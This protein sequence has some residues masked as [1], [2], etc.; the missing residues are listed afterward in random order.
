[1]WSRIQ[2]Q[3]M[4]MCGFTG[5]ACSTMT[6]AFGRGGKIQPWVIELFGLQE[7][8]KRKQI[9]TANRCLVITDKCWFI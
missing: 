1:M 5:G 8:S 7:R 6:L 4:V 3:T 9:T 2:T